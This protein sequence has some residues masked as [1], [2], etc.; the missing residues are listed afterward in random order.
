MD[1]IVG[2]YVAFSCLGS[3]SFLVTVGTAFSWILEV[4][5]LSV[6]FAFLV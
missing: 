3:R 5:G 4:F 2:G 6:V 1:Y